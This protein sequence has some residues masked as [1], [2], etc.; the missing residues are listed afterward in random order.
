MDMV[1][2]NF[3]LIALLFFWLSPTLGH[4]EE[5]FSRVSVPQAI[6]HMRTSI[7]FA[8]T[9]VTASSLLASVPHGKAGGGNAAYILQ[10]GEYN[11]V[12]LSQTGGRNIGFVAQSGYHNSVTMLQAGNGQAIITQKGLGNTALV[13][14]R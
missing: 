13:S 14:Q 12:E 4:S 7:S 1:K 10:T 11:S 6:G 2:Q 5:A 9:M 3:P 8:D